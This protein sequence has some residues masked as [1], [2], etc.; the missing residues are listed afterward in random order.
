[1]KVKKM[2]EPTS[3]QL[4][5]WKGEFGKEYTDRNALTLE[6]M[7][8]LYKKNYGVSR[9]KL[10][11]VFLGD[12]DRSIKILEVGSGLGNQLLNLQKMGFENL[13]GI[14]VNSHAIEQAKVNTKGINVVQGSAFDVPFRDGYFDLVFTSGV[15][16]HIAPADIEK[17]LREI[18]RCSRE[19]IWGFEYYADTYTEVK[20]RGHDNLLW[21]T[22]FAKL[23]LDKFQNLELVKEKRI[24]YLDNDNLDSMFLLRKRN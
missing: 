19:Y 15:L 22:D 4:E 16:I 20:Y 11:E 3:S 23:Y 6:Q 7:D 13:Y 1:M 5:R 8:E 17:A 24:K 18:H 14:E 9:T 2:R 21:K 10:N 12:L